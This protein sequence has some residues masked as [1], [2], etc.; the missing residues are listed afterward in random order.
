MILQECKKVELEEVDEQ[1]IINTPSE[2]GEGKEGSSG[3]QGG[4]TMWLVDLINYMTDTY[5]AVRDKLEEE[6]NE[7]N[8]IEEAKKKEIELER[9]RKREAEE[10]RRSKLTPEQR[11]IEDLRR[12]NNELEWEAMSARAEAERA[13]QRA[14]EAEDELEE[15]GNS[16][17][18]IYI[19]DNR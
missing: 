1:T 7:K 6:K 5:D 14:R 8:R 15:E 18:V 17:I 9:Q 4:I 2:R 10:L 11:E 13:E 3:K 12:R 16:R 19:N